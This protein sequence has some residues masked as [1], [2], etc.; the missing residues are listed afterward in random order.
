MIKQLN[1]LESAVFL[2]GAVLMVAGVALRFF[3]VEKLAPWIFLIGATC[4]STMQ[5]RQRYEGTDFTLRRLRRIMIAGDICFM[6]AAV[7][8]VENTYGFLISSFISFWPENGYI[9]YM[10]YIHNNW[11]VLLLTA[12]VL[13]LY[14]THRIEHVLRKGAK[15]N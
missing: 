4:F 8:F 14:S 15:N 6:L 5:L 13:E 2:L 12:S 11:V 10:Q 3:E 7:M 1:T 9:Y